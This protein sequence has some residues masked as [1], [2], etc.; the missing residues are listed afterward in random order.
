[1]I[2]PLTALVLLHIFML[3]KALANSRFFPQHQHRLMPQTL[4]LTISIAFSLGH[5][6]GASTWMF[7]MGDFAMV[8]RCFVACVC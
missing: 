1:V 3:M 5:M 2:L 7:C 4:A 8:T 6:V